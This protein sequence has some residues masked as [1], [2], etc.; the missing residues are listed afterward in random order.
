MAFHLVNKRSPLIIRI[1]D[2]IKINIGPYF[3]QIARFDIFYVCFVYF[4]AIAQVWINLDREHV[5]YTVM[6][7][8]MAQVPRGQGNIRKRTKRKPWKERSRSRRFSLHK[9]L[10]TFFF[11]F[12][13][14]LS[15]FLYYFYPRHLPTPTTNTH[16]Q[17]Q[18]DLYPLSTTFSYTQL[19]FGHFTW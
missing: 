1:V 14:T 19:Q 17:H 13:I 16:D 9:Y 11:V 8:K 4:A 3:L 18:K 2:R 5:F 7:L 12:S 6:L 15:Y 10:T